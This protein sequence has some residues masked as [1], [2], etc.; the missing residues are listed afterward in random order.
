MPELPPNSRPRLGQPA[1]LQLNFKAIL[2]IIIAGL[3]L[4]GVFTSYYTVE[5]D[6]VA[7]VQ[8]FGRFK[9]VVE[10]GLQFKIPFGVDSVTKVAMRRQ[11]KMEFG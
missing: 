1:P 2:A 11:L 8:R 3:V 9:T 10:P 5:A 4:I 6:S 7:V